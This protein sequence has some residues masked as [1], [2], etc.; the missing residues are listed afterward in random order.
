[1]APS[2]SAPP[3]S[4]GHLREHSGEAGVHGAPPQSLGFRH[5]TKH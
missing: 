4:T 2:H 3:A 5:D 1:V